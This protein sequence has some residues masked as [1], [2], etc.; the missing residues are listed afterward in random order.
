MLKKLLFMLLQFPPLALLPPIPPLTV[1]PH[2]VGENLLILTAVSY[3]LFLVL[4]AQVF[5]IVTTPCTEHSS[6]VFTVYHFYFTS[7]MMRTQK[8]A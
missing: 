8:E 2:T 5:T 1:S 4:V 7:K 6:S 3:I